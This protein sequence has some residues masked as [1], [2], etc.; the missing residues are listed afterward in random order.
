MA[1]SY[2]SRPQLNHKATNSI[3]YQQPVHPATVHFPIAF[4]VGTQVLDIIYGLATHANTA[5]LLANI[6]D[7]KPYLSDITRVSQLLLTVGLFS[8]IPAVLTGAYELF[9]LLSRQAIADKLAAAD[10]AEKK[11][12]VVRKT[13]PKVKMAFIHALIMDLVVAANAYNWWTRRN[14]PAGM[15]SD[16]NVLVSALQAPFFAGAGSL[17]A[18]MVYRHGVGVYAAGSMKK[19]Q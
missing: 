8:S 3:S 6:Y 14:A 11:K 12:E 1:P 13:H 17:G 7:V 10:S 16:I 18:Q 15:P 5:P 4:L 2:V 9:A 19:D